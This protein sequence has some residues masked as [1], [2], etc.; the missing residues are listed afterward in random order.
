M[1]RRGNSQFM[2]CGY[3]S[4]GL[5]TR[6]RRCGGSHGSMSGPALCLLGDL[7]QGLQHPGRQLFRGLAALAEPFADL[8]LDRAPGRPVP[9]PQGP[10]LLPTFGH[11]EHS[12]LALVPFDNGAANETFPN[13]ARNDPL[14]R[15]Q[16]LGDKTRPSWSEARLPMLPTGT[17]LDDRQAC[18]SRVCCAVPPAC[19]ESRSP[20]SGAWR[21]SGKPGKHRMG[22]C[23]RSDDA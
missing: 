3:G 9:R 4:L 5:P 7:H 22:P 17:G 20:D 10:V 19:Q 14:V 13:K 8:H 12:T 18:V 1:P 16:T 11:V 21:G 15:N 6:R 2:R 23:F